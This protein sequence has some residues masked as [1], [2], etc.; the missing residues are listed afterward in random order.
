MDIEQLN[1]TQILLLTLL[2]SFVTSIATGIVTV[3]LMGQAPQG[4][5]QTVNRIVER[6][7]EKVVP[8]PVRHS[9]AAAVGAVASQPTAATETTVVVKDDD[10]AADSIVKI[11][12]ATVRLVEKGGPESAA[13]ARG[14]VVEA[15]GVIVADR[16]STDPNLGAE[17]ILPSGERFAVTPRA[18]IAGEAV[19]I[20]DINATGTSSPK[21]VVAP[22]ADIGKVRLG[23]SVIRIGGR[24]RDS[25]DSGVVSS[26]PQTG[27]TL[28]ESTAE[29]VTAGSLLV[30]IFGEIVGMTTGQSQAQGASSYT[31][32]TEI[33]AAL[34]AKR[35]AR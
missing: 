30:T 26:L 11:Q 14:V 28:I 31:P 8:E 17:V 33:A 18:P 29:A 34:A 13:F 10:L 27:Q 9:A 24:T 16:S 7:V 25:V 15:S 6:T 2:V 21:L 19:R 20:Y 35:D 12:A 22:L 4:I 3:S 1:R 23:Q 5:T 32:A